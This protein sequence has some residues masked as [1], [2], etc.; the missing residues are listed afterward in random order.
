MIHNIEKSFSIKVTDT[1]L[2][3]AV[4]V[5]NRTRQLMTEL[6][7]LRKNDPPAVSG[8]E[9]MRIA[10]TGMSTPR[11]QFNHRLEA[12][13][14]ELEARQAGEAGK[15]RLM[16]VGGACD[17]HE[18]IDFIE[19][20]GAYVVADGLCFGLRHY[21]GMIDEEAENPLGA[22]VDRHLDRVPCPSII[23]GFDHGYPILKEIMNHWGIHGV[24]SARLK[25]CDHWAGGR[26]MLRDGLQKDNG[27]PLL[28]LEREYSTTESG[29]ISTRVQAFLEMLEV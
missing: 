17:S 24:V 20:R 7:E 15:P 13:I 4:S 9:Y 16:M 18:F 21:G 28:D 27:V 2:R 12:L 22:I 19:S 10:L 1:D 14:P 25:F 29:Q 8:A 3:H 26:K 23:N 6:N 5:Y 11:E